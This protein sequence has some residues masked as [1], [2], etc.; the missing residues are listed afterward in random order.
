VEEHV[1]NSVVRGSIAAV[2]ALLIIPV[3]A[4]RHDDLP[5]RI[6]ALCDR[7][8]RP[9]APGG[10]AVA[11][12]KDGRVLFKKAYGFA[13]SEHRVRF[14]TSTVADY[15]SVA[16][17]F[18][19][20]AVA[21]LVQDGR[22]NLDDEIH[23]FLPELP[24]FGERITVRHLLHHTSGIRDWVGLAKLSGRYSGDAITRDF[25][26]KL[27]A[28]QRDLNFKP[29][30]SFQY[31][32]TGYF[33]LARIVERVTGQSFPQWTRE[34]IFEP[35]GMS[36]THFSDD[37]REIIPN[38]ASSYERADNGLYVNS[39]DQLE[40]NGSSSLFS[41]LDDMV[42]W[43]ANYETHEL[44]GPEVWGMMTRPGTLN[45]GEETNYGFGVSLDSS[46]GLASMGHGGSW[47]GYLCQV[48]YYPEQKIATVLSVN[49]DPAGFQLSD[50]LM[51]TMLHDQKPQDAGR[52]TPP[53]RAEA[54]ID[55]KVLADYVG[56]YLRSGNMMWVRRADD[57][58]TVVFPG[59][60]RAWV[61][62]EAEDRFFSRDFDLE[63]SFLRGGDGAV[64]GLAYSVNG[65]MGEPYRRVD[66]RASAFVDVDDLV[67]EY[68]CPELE[69]TYSI[70]VRND[71]V[72]L[73]HLHNEDVLLQQLDRDTFR[74]D[75]WWCTRIR[76]TRDSEDRVT[77]FT[78]DADSN[79]IRNLRFVRL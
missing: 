41:T 75:A 47:A 12:I 21:T 58:L 66:D 42:K 77:G 73:E 9:D 54:V 20:F 63:V 74:G 28:S 70:V 64:N 48:S 76:V 1:V 44:G 67:G 6:E 29:G 33:L 49:R 19:G 37:Y 79:N 10:F 57:Q 7:C 24:D 23:R 78:L 51:R 14:A 31:S 56:P 69:T 30:E 71:R 45:S 27:A 25:L 59:G 61:Y 2:C 35:L 34:Q 46:Q 68:H 55:P 4:C 62:P 40:S 11:V 53:E 22:L 16:K 52:E 38:R 65:R 17:Q 36:D 13:D 39:F 32:N 26:M 18:T 50:E 60:Q 43:M 5:A 8:D 3:W 72:I 15:A